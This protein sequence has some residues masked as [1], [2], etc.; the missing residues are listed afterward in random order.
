M[1]KYSIIILWLCLLLT[2]CLAQ[3]NA[4]CPAI[5]VSGPSGIV[6]VGET[7]RY[8]V[9]VSPFDGSS[10]ITYTWSLSAGEIKSGQGTTE[11]EVIQ[12]SACPITATVHVGGL[13]DGCPAYSSETATCCGPVPLAENLGTFT[14][15]LTKKNLATL[16]DTI[17]NNSRRDYV[18]FYLLIYGTDERDV[19]RRKL[20]IKTLFPN[21][22]RITYV[23][24]GGSDDKVVVWAVPAGA[25]PP[26]P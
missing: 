19:E 12:P 22:D 26:A 10:K 1:S 6:E 25:I 4:T 20:K 7:A 8:T 16:K 14:G 21:S 15:T 24:A 17:S 13:P 18:Q 5:E 3:Q 9:R 23:D 2:P 11:L